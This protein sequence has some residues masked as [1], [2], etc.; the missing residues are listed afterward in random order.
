MGFAILLAAPMIGLVPVGF[1]AEAAAEEASGEIEFIMSRFDGRFHFAIQHEDAILLRSPGYATELAARE[2][3]DEVRTQSRRIKN[4][5]LRSLDKE[6]HYFIVEGA[7]GDVL[8]TSPLYPT[9]EE[10]HRAREHFK[11]AMIAAGKL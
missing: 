3:M 1:T 9:S 7:A 10:A 4:L 11:K 6:K 5:P 8:A 2:A